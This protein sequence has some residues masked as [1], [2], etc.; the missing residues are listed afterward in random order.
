MTDANAST[1]SWTSAHRSTLI[2]I[3]A[4]AA[5]WAGAA[6]NGERWGQTL[7]EIRAAFPS[8]V[9]LTTQQLADKLSA[10]EPVLL[11]DAREPEEY[12]VSHIDGAVRV[13][14]ASAALNA[15]RADSREPTVVVYC[16]VGYRS[17]RLVSWLK[18]RGV[19]N[20]FNLEGSLFLWANEG[21]PLARGDEPAR[22]VHPY[23]D[24]WGEFLNEALR[25]E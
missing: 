7:A 9:H 12:E 8:V 3:L 11:L 16:S 5:A 18:A 19:K 4:T 23:D 22:R 10:A 15:I 14:T 24:D 25:A 6:T 13:T 21:R 1:R 20:V 17:S 2:A